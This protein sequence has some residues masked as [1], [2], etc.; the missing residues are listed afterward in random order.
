[1]EQG[2]LV[3]L[4]FGVADVPDAAV[5]FL[6]AH[7]VGAAP[8]LLSNQITP[9]ELTQLIKDY[10]I[11]AVVST[12]PRL[13]PLRTI[14]SGTL[15]DLEGNDT[16]D[17]A[18]RPASPH[19]L[20]SVILTSGTT[21]RPKAVACAQENLVAGARLYK[22]LIRPGTER[23]PILHAFPLGSSA[24]QSM[25]VEPLTTGL[26]SLTLS[27]FDP[28]EFCAVVED[29]AIEKIAIVPAMAISVLNMDAPRG[30]D[31]AS[32]RRL[33]LGGAPAPTSVIAGLSESFWNAEIV[34]GYSVTEAMPAS[35]EMRFG[36]HPPASVGLPFKATQLRIV[37]ANDHPL[38]PRAEGQ[39]A[40]RYP[41]IVPRWYFRDDE[42]T[43]AVFRNGWTMTGDIGYRDDDGFI[44]LTDRMKD[45]INHGGTMV[46]SVGVEDVLYQHP[47][48][49]EA[50]VFPL[51]HATLGEQIAA[52]VVPRAGLSVRELKDFARAR[53]NKDSVPSRIFVLQAL[54]RNAMGKVLKNELRQ[55]FEGGSTQRN[56]GSD[57]STWTET[58]RLVG[59]IWAR[60]LGVS[61][62][63]RHEEFVEVG[64]H[65]LL[66]LAVTSELN[67]AFT[68]DLPEDVLF[69]YS[70]IDAMASL[71]DDLRRHDPTGRRGAQEG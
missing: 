40:L 50:A 71:I 54:P 1:V 62:I 27:R 69:E 65:S 32:V 25:L 36:H 31:L 14:W 56:S 46:S 60:V 9:A 2:S 57:P 43:A 45:V 48:V 49:A 26:P 42:S 53:L 22:E 61:S 17:V 29:L 24:G 63:G 52:A 47:L 44:Y 21:G 5:A 68:V 66:A 10:P 15:D 64:G 67:D 39:I 13:R 6:A 16:G 58:E 7:K 51:P 11:R 23:K 33:L 34:V 4:L 38:P 59:S 55:R 3:A 20:A 28:D 18:T 70:T 30:R 12:Q 8:L 35:T 41:G 37:D 19:D